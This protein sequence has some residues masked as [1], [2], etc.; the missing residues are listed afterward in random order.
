MIMLRSAVTH[1]FQASSD[2]GQIGAQD[3]VIV[4]AETGVHSAMRSVCPEAYTGGLSAL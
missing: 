3:S 2:R 1:S 4:P